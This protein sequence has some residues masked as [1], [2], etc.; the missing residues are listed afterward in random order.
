MRSWVDA[1]LD[2]PKVARAAFEET[3]KEYEASQARVR[4]LESAL[5]ELRAW[6]MLNPPD[7][8]PEPIADGP[9]ITA[10]S[11]LRSGQSDGGDRQQI[12]LFEKRTVEEME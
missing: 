7:G 11:S 4:K 9:W 10:V 8:N 1:Q 3:F 5:R 12:D 6:D 2:D